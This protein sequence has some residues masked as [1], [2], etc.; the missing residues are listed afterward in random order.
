MTIEDEEPRPL[1]E[2]A[3]APEVLQNA[4]RELAAD[5]PRPLA[6]GRHDALFHDAVARARGR[7]TPRFITGLAFATACL[8]GAVIV[9]SLI[10]TAPV[11]PPAAPVAEVMAS[12][13]ASYSLQGRTLSIQSGRMVLQP[14]G[15]LTVRAGEIEL[16]LQGARVAVD[17]TD[18]GVV[19]RVESGEAIV[20]RNG[21]STRV[22]AGEKLE[23]MSEPL[24]L[25]PV[26]GHAEGCGAG[27]EACLGERAAR[28]G[29]EAETAL[30]ELGFLAFERGD[31]RVAVERFRE[32]QRRFPDGVLGPEASVGL[33]LGLSRLRDGEAASD[34]A[35][36][37]LERFPTDP[38]A[39]RIRLMVR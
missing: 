33:M 30:Y 9:S 36:R 20:N 14:R 18:L 16:A 21:V 3:S 2:L 13:G 23:A 26:V 10:H 1:L 35:K 8:V 5:E 6:R 24:A 4:L 29:L 27:D 11:A 12:A 15:P 34:E 37:F 32:H 7:R 25:A 19:V 22:A 38:R 39:P 28:E 17:V 31:A